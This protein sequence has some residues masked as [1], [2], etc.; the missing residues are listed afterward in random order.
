MTGMTAR[1]GS[2]AIATME[3]DASRSL[4][5]AN[6]RAA[7]LT[8]ARDL[9]VRSGVDRVS[10]DTVAAEAG[11]S[12]A[13]VYSYFGDKQHLFLAILDDASASLSR[14]ADQALRAHLSEDAKIRSV[15]DLESALCAAAID[16]GVAMIGSADYAAVFA[17]VAQ[18]GRQD[19]QAEGDPITDGPEQAFS[20][21]VAHFAEQGLLD[22]PDAAL[23]TDHF[24]ALTMLRAYNRYPDP[25]E[26]DE[27]L[28]REVISNGVHAFVRAYAP[29]P[30]AR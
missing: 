27:S 19:S 28:I 17:L 16:L 22:A 7:I 15:D 5:A 25:R 2:T 1:D 30:E 4:R 3:E 21:R 26:V 18:R 11:V 10:M 6:K 9:F 14:A 29:R 23:A 24:I 20:E 8:A 12:K 13:T